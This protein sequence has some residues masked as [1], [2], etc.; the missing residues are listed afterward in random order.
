MSQQRKTKKYR[1][2]KLL[3][4]PL[5]ARTHRWQWAGYIGAGP[6]Y[7]SD[8]LSLG[9]RALAS[10]APDYSSGGSIIYT[11]NSR[12]NGWHIAGGIVAEK[13]LGNNWLFSAGLG[14]NSSTW[15]TKSEKFKDSIFSGALS[16]TVKISTEQHKNQLWMAEVPL[17]FS[18]RISGKK[19]GSLWWTIGMNNQFRIS[20]NQ[21]TTKASSSTASLSDRRSLNSSS[22]F[23]QPQ[24]R[25]GLL[26]NHNGMV[27]WQIQPLFQY[28]L[29]GVYT[30]RYS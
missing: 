26:Y 28:S 8:P 19:A 5:K 17:Q 4:S 25:A 9:P 21:N 27:H 13:K 14:I 15:T 24:F 22:R 16:S 2:A 29:T 1:P 20:L 12:E 11:T 3:P 23:Y 7:P 6:N 18:N 10:N 30:S